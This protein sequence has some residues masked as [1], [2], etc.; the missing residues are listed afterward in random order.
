MR[1]WCP[2]RPV[3]D[4]RDRRFRFL[5]RFPHTAM[6]HQ[7]PRRACDRSKKA[8][9]HSLL[10]Q[11]LSRDQLPSRCA[12]RMTRTN[13]AIG[14]RPAPSSGSR[15]TRPPSPTCGRNL[16]AW[17]RVASGRRSASVGAAPPALWTSSERMLSLMSRTSASPGSSS[18]RSGT[19]PASLNQL[20]RR[21]GAC[22]QVHVGVLLAGVH[23]G[24]HEQKRHRRRLR[25]DVGNPGGYGDTIWG[26]QGDRRG[27]A[28]DCNRK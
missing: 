22:Q 1:L 20:A 2:Q 8:H 15:F 7:A 24:L 9:R 23:E 6:S 13:G 16:D 17:A 27:H 5:I 3:V 4:R 26:R 28:G 10:R 25:L 12:S 21:R 19:I 18:G 14:R 11:A